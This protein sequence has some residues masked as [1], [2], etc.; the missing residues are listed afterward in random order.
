ME[1]IQAFH[2]PLTCRTYM[3]HTFYI[4]TT[5]VND[6]QVVKL[7]SVFYGIHP[8]IHIV[9]QTNQCDAKSNKYRFT[10]LKLSAV[11]KQKYS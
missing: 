3:T 10:H 5:G 11:H 2:G 8:Q 7:C 4:H 6:R 1:W 9:D